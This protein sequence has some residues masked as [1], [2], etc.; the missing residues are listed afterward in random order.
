MHKMPSIKPVVKR[1]LQ[2]YGLKHCFSN[3]VPRR[4]VKEF[5][6]TRMRNSGKSFTGGPKSVCTSVNERSVLIMVF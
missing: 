2:K 4:G 1:T 3:W 5:R 6:Q